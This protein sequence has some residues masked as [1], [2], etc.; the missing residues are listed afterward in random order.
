LSERQHGHPT[1][2]R[3]IFSFLLDTNVYGVTDMNTISRKHTRTMLRPLAALLIMGMAG[4]VYATSNELESTCVAASVDSA[5]N[6]SPLCS[7]TMQDVAVTA[8]AA[9]RGTTNDLHPYIGFADADGMNAEASGVYSMAIGAGA[10]ATDDYGYALAFG[11]DAQAEGWATAAFGYGSKVTALGG[12]ALG[13]D[14]QVVGDPDSSAG[15]FGVAI[16]FKAKVAASYGDG[17]S[18][19]AYAGVAI[20]QYAWA[21]GKESVALGANSKAFEDYTVA[22]GSESQRRRI[23][24]MDGG[25]AD[26]DAVNMQQL[27]GVAG[28]LGGEAGF[29]GSGN[30]VLPTYNIQG[31]EHRSVGAALNALDDGLKATNER[32]DE[33]ADGSGGDGLV[34]RDDATGDITVGKDTGG[35]TVDFTG[36]NG[37]RVLTGVAAGLVAA[38][39]TQAVNGGQLHDL[40][41]NL[42]SQLDG[43]DGRIGIIEQGMG[44]EPIGD[45]GDG[46]GNDPVHGPGSGTGDNSLVVGNGAD[47]SGKDSTAVGNGAVASGSGSTATGA[48]A[49]ASGSNSTANG[50]GA[51]A[52]GANSTALGANASATG[53]NSVAL[54]AGSVA[55]RDNSVSVGSEGHERQITNVAAGTHR[56][57][58]ANW[59]QVQDAVNGVKDWANQKF[60][61]IDKRIHRMGAMS[62]ASTQMAIN[63]AGATTKA[64]RLSMGVGMQ[65]GQKAMAIGYGKSFGERMRFSIGGSFSGSETQIGAGFG[66]DL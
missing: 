31:E 56:T 62:A 13:S 61:H 12:L 52:S 40:Q 30:F 9:V 34:S 27:K 5:T 2:G 1:A 8:S 39:S 19:D 53:N 29:D 36:T 4:S 10:K 45:P 14:A 51:T 23:V 48:G 38:G 16:G 59:G 26:F 35:S 42:Q 54:G 60:H 15:E 6:A 22:V 20:G 66:V 33:L 25:I 3:N 58:A 7:P 50:A 55:D 18:S 44:D 46:N 49:V 24:N 43:L 17:W 63:A 11:A 47:A 37:A 28:A 32:V 41:Q 64:G 65:G 57:D 21:A